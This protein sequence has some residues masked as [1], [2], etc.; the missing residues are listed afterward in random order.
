MNLIIDCPAFAQR[1]GHV[2]M[3]YCTLSDP[4]QAK[5][6]KA[7]R[8]TMPGCGAFATSTSFV[9]DRQFQVAADNASH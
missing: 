1:A 2:L 3:R 5:N 9:V 8:C 6:P 7:A 4:E